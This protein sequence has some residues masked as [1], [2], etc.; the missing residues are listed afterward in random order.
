[1]DTLVREANLGL[2]SA[3]VA[4]RKFPLQR[5]LCTDMKKYHANVEKFDSS[6]LVSPVGTG[7]QHCHNEE[8]SA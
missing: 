3:T 2:G 6:L 8:R 5:H 4:V 1:V 7:S